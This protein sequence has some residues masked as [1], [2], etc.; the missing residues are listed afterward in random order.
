MQNQTIIDSIIDTLNEMQ[1][2]SE[3]VTKELEQIKE[4]ILSSEKKPQTTETKQ[5]EATS[6]NAQKPMYNQ[7]E[8]PDTTK[9][10]TRKTVSPQH[11]DNRGR[12]IDIEDEVHVL[13]SGLFRGKR[14]VITKL[15]K[16]RVMIRLASGKT[17][18]RKS[19]NLQ[20]VT[21]DV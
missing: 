7:R 6:A 19:S 11:T 14:G 4:E 20:I 8:S 10:N 1:L 16:A 17:T 9:R 15:D 13:R 18:N 2:S 3:T 12:R 21:K 5:P